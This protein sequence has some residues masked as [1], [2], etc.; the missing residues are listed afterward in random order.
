[1]TIERA[2]VGIIGGGVVGTSI[3]YRLARA[4]KR[5]V[6]V[7]R[8]DLAAGSS[9]ACDKAI[10]VQSKAP[11]IHLEL[12]LRS[13]EL[14]RGL[15]RELDYDIEYKPRGGMIVIQTRDQLEVMEHLAARQRE[16]G[17][18]VRRLSPEEA[19]AREPVLSGD[20]LGA[21]H[22]SRDAE[23]N[24]I[25]LTLGLARAAARHGAKILVHTEAKGIGVRNGRAESIFTDQGEIR[26]EVIV[27][28]A[29]VWA[30]QIGRMVGLEVPIVPRRGQILVT[31]RVPEMVGSVI[32]CARYI[33]AKYHPDLARNGEG[34]VA[35]LGVGLSLG[36]TRSGNILIGGSREFV[37]YDRRTTRE[38][39][40]TIGRHALQ[41]APG[42]KGI[43]AIRAFAGLRPYTPDGLPIL[44]FV[45]GVGNF[46]MAAGHE[47][48]G[49]ALAAITGQLIAELV[50]GGQAST[51]LEPFR[52]SRFKGGGR[53][54]G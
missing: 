7:E 36:Q 10:F 11:G 1:M 54:A 42:L 24:P 44:G 17:L 6:L 22:S 15:S 53:T 49:I 48:D 20:L 52:L 45:E 23:V 8:A 31:E 37:G 26:A 32:L 25:R 12:A 34:E 4:G 51:S 50:L 9:G 38:A 14:Y 30:P 19:R 35:R 16:S 29:G 33:A 13:A 5:V 46:I 21:T 41:I 39:M 18:D 3:A 40:V 2:E 28:A 27:N 47:G 43:R